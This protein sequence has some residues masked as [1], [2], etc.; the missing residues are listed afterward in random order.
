MRERIGL[1]LVFLCLLGAVVLGFDMIA[2]PQRHLRGYT[3]GEMHRELKKTEIQIL[4]IS[5]VV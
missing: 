5:E 3:G 4:G 1:P 2:R